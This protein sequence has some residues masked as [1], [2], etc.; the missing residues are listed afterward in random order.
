MSSFSP[1]LQ[2]LEGPS[3]LFSPADFADADDTRPAAAIF[4]I[5]GSGQTAPYSVA[6]NAILGKHSDEIRAKAAS[7]LSL[8]N[9]WKK[10]LR[11]FMAKKNTDLLDFL[12][13]NLS[14]H[15]TLGKGEQILRKFG[16]PSVHPGHPSLRDIVLDVSGAD[17]IAAL[18]EDFRK[19]RTDD[20]L[21][22]FLGGVKFIFDQYREAGEEA[23]RHEAILREKMAT[24][25][26]IQ[27]RIS[28]LFEI[29]P[30]EKFQ[31][32]MEA[33]E[34]YLG[35]IFQM[36]Q[37]EDTYKGLISAYRKFL[38]LRD[39]VLMMRTI[40]STENEPVCCICIQE[41]VQFTITPCGHTFC[42]TCVRKQSGSC[43][44]CRGPIREKIKLFF[45]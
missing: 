4:D 10:R 45:G 12:N 6:M 43:F 11:D 35:H 19:L 18:R 39:V 16:S 38:V 13:V 27:S 9:G 24:F 17:T 14:S 22:D 37:I 1:A 2:G 30:N 8:P 28:A 31:P 42:Q 41:A 32:L 33:T 34:A 40:Q 23:L 25:D 5:G 3:G 29:E 20:E 21:K 44:F 7:G 15:P 26:K 36:N